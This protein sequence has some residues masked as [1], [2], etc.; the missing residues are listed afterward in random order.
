MDRSCRD[1]DERVMPG[2]GRNRRGR[3]DLGPPRRRRRDGDARRRERGASSGGGDEARRAGTLSKLFDR[4]DRARW[5]SSMRVVKDAGIASLAATRRRHGGRARTISSR[6]EGW[7]DPLPAVHPRLVGR[8]HR[9]R[10]PRDG[11]GARSS[12]RPNSRASSISR[13]SWDGGRH[14][15]DQ[16]AETASSSTAVPVRS[17]S[18][19]GPASPNEPQISG[20]L[21][22]RRA[23]APLVAHGSVR[24][25]ERLR[26]RDRA[27]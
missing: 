4:R 3:A 9:D 22:P 26:R 5:L 21:A 17:R 25:V 18:S 27:T 11:A 20:S 2:D 23:R 6:G 8:V 7:R 1:R 13:Q 16:G 10:G 12:T 14:P 24:P 19:S 15:A